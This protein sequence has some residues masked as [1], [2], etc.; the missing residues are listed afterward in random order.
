MDPMFSAFATKHPDAPL[1][2]YENRV[3]DAPAP[4][5][6]PTGASTGA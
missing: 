4:V 2:D 6:D 1:T 3:H 5:T